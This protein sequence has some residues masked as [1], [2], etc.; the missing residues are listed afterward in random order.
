MGT[1]HLILVYY[2]GQYHIAQYG[3]WDGYPGG[4]GVTVLHF[5]SDPA[6]L[7]KLT[8]VLDAGESSS[9]EASTAVRAA[10]DAKTVVASTAATASARARALSVRGAVTSMS[11]TADTAPSAG[12]NA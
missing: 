7:A 11:G 1:R 6:K 12:P 4:Q 3:Q 5:V 8:A 10:G 2:K 9:A